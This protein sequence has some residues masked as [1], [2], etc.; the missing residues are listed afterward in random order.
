M[1]QSAT[2]KLTAAFLAIVM[3]ISITF[4]V[5][6]YRISSQEINDRLQSLESS[7][8]DEFG[9]PVPFNNYGG[10]SGANGDGDSSNQMDTP[11]PS[12]F[13]MKE[14][15]KASFQIVLSLIYINVC[16][17]IIGGLCAYFLAKRT[18]QPIADAHEAQSR[19]TSDASHELRTP[20]AAMKTELEVN[21][22]DKDLPADEAR[23]ILESNLEEVN[24]LIRLSEMLLKLSRLE[25]DNLEVTRV[26]LPKILNDTIKLYPD[27]K[28]RFV[29]E[30]P[31]KAA[32][33]ANQPAISELASIL[34]DN[35]IKYSPE[36]TPI[37]IRIYTQRNNLGLAVSNAG[38]KIPEELLPKL[39][40]RFFQADSSRTNS[41]K[42]GYGL[43]LSIAKK[44]VDLHHGSIS[45]TSTDA[46]TTFTVLLPIIR[47]SSG[48]FN[49]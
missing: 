18:L 30:A 19:F 47:N 5:V 23:E 28:D 29:I 3:A 13:L 21:L 27:A 15:R 26:D 22:R 49:N 32:T 38:K 2:L 33:R 43:G 41:A 4:S 40:N 8:I 12:T 9:T 24:K 39:F 48:E 42:N 31:K 10:H 44:I 1:F 35:A 34:I 36:K 7:I 46:S 17:F 14:S 6:I 37:K 11:D 16:V 25:H 20:L 45:V